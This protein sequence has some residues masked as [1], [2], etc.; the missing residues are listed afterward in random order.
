MSQKAS[1]ASVALDITDREAI[2]QFRSALA[3]AKY[4]VEHMRPLL[5]AESNNIT[6][7]PTDIPIIV[8]M[9]PKGER[10]AS[11]LRLFLLGLAVPRS[12]ARAALAP[13]SVERALRLGVI[14]RSSGGI[15]SAVRILPAGDVL[16][17]CDR[18]PEGSPDLSADHVMGVASSSILLASLTVRRTIARALDV[19]SGG[20]IQSILAARHAER[21]IA[22]DINPRALNFTA[23]NALLNGLDN[24]ECRAGSFFEPVAGERFEL[25]VSNPPFVI[26]PE[27][28]MIF[29]DSG[30]RGDD[31]SRMVVR[32][33]A[34]H[35]TE[36]GLAFILV[37]WGIG[38]G[39]QW[40][41][42]L[43][44]WVADLPC[45]I[46]ILHHS[47]EVPLLYA[48][49]WN[50]PIQSRAQDFGAALDHWMAYLAELGFAA[51]GYGAIILR[52]RSAATNWVRFDDLGGQSEP[53]SGTQIADL[54]DAQDFIVGL[55]DDRSLLDARLAVA[56]EHRLEQIL[57]YR[58]GSF[59]VDTA[60]LRLE[61]GLRFATG[62]DAFS[63]HLLSRLEGRTLGEAIR[64]TAE[65]FPS[66][67]I[68][69]S[70]FESSALQLVKLTLALGLVR[71]VRQESER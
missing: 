17:A 23:F 52:R 71:L 38:K 57:R 2:A 10:L 48:A 28:A 35:L 5:R 43:R 51:V 53:A 32:E 15:E 37:S 70:E 13:L 24:V 14:R 67:G 64:E 54:I 25:I 41:D 63:A 8:R 21:V 50:S 19:G 60:S 39:E 18:K 26:S 3:S 65:L 4:D 61:S 62:L 45:D 46:W 7:R 36:G 68:P 34:E 69:Y 30:M 58:D 49:S 22:C 44:P 1:E 20:G 33:A 29:R 47:G 59:T 56:P 40:Q 42:R 9:L 11:L 6:P 12:E 27:S 16:I 31:V 66:D 55:K